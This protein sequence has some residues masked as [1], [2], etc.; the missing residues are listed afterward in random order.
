MAG[1]RLGARYPSASDGQTPVTASSVG[2]YF[3]CKS[4]TEGRR[5]L[6]DRGL[7]VSQPAAPDS[8]A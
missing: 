7:V 3:C 8:V 4:L 6:L 1:K 5:N 2:R